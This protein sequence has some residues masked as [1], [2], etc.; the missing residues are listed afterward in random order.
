MIS[1]SH[2]TALDTPPEAF[3]DAAAA[4]GFGGVGLRIA[5]P[6]HAPE[7]WPV[8]GDMQRIR[9]LRRRAK[10][11]GICVF[12]AE[13][14][15]I[16]ADFS[17][18]AS[19]PAL[20]AA[21]EIGASYVV[22]GGFDENE[23]RMVNSYRL[24]AEAAGNLALTVVIEFI[25]FRPLRTLDDAVRVQQRVDHPALK[26]LVDMLH[27]DR[28]GGTAARVA[29]LDPD[30]LGYIH[31]CDAP[32]TRPAPDGLATEARTGRFYPGDGGLPLRDILA[33]LPAEMSFSLEAPDPRF[34][35]LPATERLAIAG[36]KTLGFLGR[37]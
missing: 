31:I 26:L 10:D 1:V 35:H 32:A 14:F 34:A 2:L 29:A 23:D 3:I 16:A 18:D 21:A 33:V 19:R 30:A 8:V 13:S 28:T 27:L 24:L 22:A 11:A 25:S 6:S 9:A 20:E 37:R 17:I 12:E 36:E 4:A 5:P 15:G 7:Q